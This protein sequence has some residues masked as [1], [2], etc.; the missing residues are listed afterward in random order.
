ML[1]QHSC[2]DTHAPTLML[3]LMR[4]ATCAACAAGREVMASAG[5][6]AAATTADVSVAC[7]GGVGVYSHTPGRGLCLPT[8]AHMHSLART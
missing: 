2:A 8:Y 1:R 5:A 3:T 4:H 7:R 6:T